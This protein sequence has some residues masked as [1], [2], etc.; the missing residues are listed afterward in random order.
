MESLPKMD[1]ATFVASKHAPTDAEW[2]DLMEAFAEEGR[3][4][5]ARDACICYADGFL[6]ELRS[7][8]LFYVH[9]WWYAPNGHATIES[10]EADLHRWRQEWE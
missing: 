10:A 7:D 4:A 1:L 2:L 8:A 3:A 5:P 9:A 6:I